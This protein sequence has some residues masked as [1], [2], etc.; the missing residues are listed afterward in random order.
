MP[1]EI[2]DD[3][4]DEPARRSD[5]KDSPKADY[6]PGT[7]GTLSPLRPALWGIAEFLTPQGV[8]RRPF[9]RGALLAADLGLCARRLLV[10]LGL[11]PGI[12]DAHEEVAG[13]RAAA[14]D[15]ERV[16]PLGWVLEPR[17]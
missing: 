1:A 13:H 11:R 16:R 9:E 17:R 4:H 15:D 2:D 6:A 7:D 5:T 3:S 8:Q 12:F 14:L 10:D